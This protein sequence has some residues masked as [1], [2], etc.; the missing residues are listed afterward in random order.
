MSKT[1]W[2]VAGAAALFA[3]QKF[4]GVGIPRRKAAQ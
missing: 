2:F 1:M 4:A 3:I